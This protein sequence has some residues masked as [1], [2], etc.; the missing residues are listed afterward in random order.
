MSQ[1]KIVKEEPSIVKGTNALELG[2]DDWKKI[3]KGAGIAFG[4]SFLLLLANQ[5]ETIS[6]QLDFGVYEAIS[7]AVVSTLVNTIRKY[8]TD[9]REN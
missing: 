8:V 4:S 5:L 2:W 9:T 3:L 6:S 7:I 1:T